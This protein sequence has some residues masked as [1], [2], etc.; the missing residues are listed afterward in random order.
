M[1]HVTRILL[2]GLVAACQ[3]GSGGSSGGSLQVRWSGREPGRL[4][5]GA[6]AGWC[7][8]RH[9]LEVRSI[10]GDTGVALALYPAE[11]LT[12]GVYRVV[13]PNRAESLPPA[14]A[15]AL[16]WLTPKIVQGFRGE[17]GSVRLQRSSSGQVSGEMSLR[18]RSVVDTER[19]T[20]TGSFQGLSLQ[21]QPPHCGRP[22]APD[23]AP[24]PQ[25][26]S[27]H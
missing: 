3:S 24:E 23:E 18:A 14:A 2:L 11:T 7:A 6:T 21:L 10:Q 13:E 12:A 25:D 20:I 4:S 19:V 26:T 5:G 8:P 1:K 15:V 22:G 9:V 16:R 17:S 27:V